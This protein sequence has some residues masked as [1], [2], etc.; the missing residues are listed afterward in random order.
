MD[1][2]F[3]EGTKDAVRRRLSVDVRSL[4][5]LRVSLALLILADLAMRARNVVFYTDAGVLPR[6]TQTEVLAPAALSLH[7]LSGSVEA[8]A[9]LFGV[10]AVFAV[11]LLV[12]YRTRVVLFVSLVLL[13]SLH[14]RNHYVLNAGDRLL[15]VTLFLCLFMPLGRRYSVDAYRNAAGG[16]RDETVFSAGTAV[17]LLHAVLVYTSNF[18]FKLHAD[19]LWLTGDAVAHVLRMGRY[20]VLVGDY[21]ADIGVVLVAVNWLWLALLGGSAVLVLTTRR[22]RVAVVSAYVSAHL[23]MFLTMRLG[24]FPFVAVA[25]LL[26]FLPASVWDAAEKRLPRLPSSL[27][28]RLEDGFGGSSEDGPGRREVVAK[29]GSVIVVFFLVFTAFWQAVA[30]GYVSD[31]VSEAV[32]DDLEP[33][34]YLSWSMFVVETQPV[35]RWF[36]AEAT[37]DSGETRN[38]DVFAEG[39]ADRPPDVGATYPTTLWHRYMNSLRYAGETEKRALAEYLC[40]RATESYGDGVA[41]LTIEHIEQPTRPDGYGE[42]ERAV[43]WRQDC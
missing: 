42:P 16:N 15:R 7:T 24:T 32:G 12:G 22:V 36:V 10:A 2:R 37:L 1:S 25:V 30:L 4:A 34:E 27:C 33:S 9:F 23:G 39:A 6:E 43:T 35:D 18:L 3:P 11:A 31:P 8:Q 20:T 26:P 17:F 40:R 5:F 21:I 13:L 41:E 38:M 28:R 19:G 14:A 29:F